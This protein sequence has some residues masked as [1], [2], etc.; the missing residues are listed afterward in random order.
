FLIATGIYSQKPELYFLP[1][2][3]SLG[4]GPLLYLFINRLIFLQ[5]ISR[6]I[7]ILHLLPLL[8]QFLFY[9]ICFFQT[10]NTK[11]DIYAGY[12]ETIIKPLQ[13]LITY[14][15]VSFYIYLSFKEIN[16]YKLQLNDYYSNTDKIEL[17]WLKKLLYVFM[18]YYTVSIF[19]VIISYSFNFSENYFP[20]DF[21]RCIIIFTIAVYAANQTTLTCIQQNIQTVQEHAPIVQQSEPIIPAEPANSLLQ[22]SNEFRLEKPKEINNE[23]LQ[24]IL[25]KVEKEELYLNEELTI[26]DLAKQLGYSTKTI[27]YTINKG[28]QKSFS[29]FINEYRVNLFKE[30]K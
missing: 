28:L 29:L 16:F 17:Q 20:S 22:N 30:K 13:I 15:S 14:I 1:V 26:A 6:I 3:L 4:I 5:P 21:I 18:F 23:L 8:I 10:I 9:L 2:I 27:S 25:A 24:S 19:F 12:Y 7:V 11:Y